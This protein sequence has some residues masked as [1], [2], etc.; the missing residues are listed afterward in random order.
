MMC[1]MAHRILNRLRCLLHLDN[2]NKDQLMALVYQ[3]PSCIGS[4]RVCAMAFHRSI[5]G[6]LGNAHFSC[7]GFP[8]RSASESVNSWAAGKSPAS[9]NPSDGLLMKSFT[10]L[11][12]CPLLPVLLMAH[13]LNLTAAA[14]SEAKRLIPDMCSADA[15][16]H[17][18][19]LAVDS[20]VS[21]QIDT[22]L[23]CC[24]K[25]FCVPALSHQ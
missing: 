22:R 13:E 4:T 24:C 21:M 1:S 23:F 6:R 9:E 20:P 18:S 3:K 14:A 25:A 7:R 17:S 8:S 16:G 12:A 11:G 19:Q 5:Q 2:G 10:F 15:F